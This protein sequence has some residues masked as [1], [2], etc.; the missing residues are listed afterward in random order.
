MEIELIKFNASK[1]ARVEELTKSSLSEIMQRVSVKDLTIFV[2]AGL[3]LKNV[4]KAGELIDTYL[5]DENNSIFSLQLLIQR[6]LQE[7]GFFPKSVNLE[8]LADKI[9]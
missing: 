6:K 2:F 8:E 9:Q 4:E 5:E 7:A 3:S 1:I